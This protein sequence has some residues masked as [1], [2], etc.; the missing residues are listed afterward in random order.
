MKSEAVRDVAQ[1]LHEYFAFALNLTAKLGRYGAVQES[2]RDT[3]AP[4]LRPAA[5][6]HRV[7]LAVRTPLESFRNSECAVSLFIY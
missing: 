5:L 3:G 6:L 1:Q 4:Q 2:E 7:T